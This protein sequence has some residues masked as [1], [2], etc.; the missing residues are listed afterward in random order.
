MQLDAWG[1]ADGYHDIDGVWHETSD[2]TRG[3]LRAAMGEPQ[4]IEPQWFVAA[5]TRH[6]L[7]GPCRLVL[8]DGTDRGVIDV[9]DGDV[10]AGYHWLH[11]TDGGPTTWL[12]VHPA[13]CPPAPAGWGAAA[14]TYSLWR[15][16]GWGIGDLEDV[17]ELGAAVAAKGG[18][19]LLLSPLHAPAPTTPQEDS[20]YY[21]SSRRWLNPLLLPLP[22]PAPAAV[23]NTPGGRIER[24]TVWAA[25]RHALAEQFEGERDHEH[26][27]R[28]AELQGDELT[29]FCAYDALADEHGPDWRQWPSQFR[30]PTSP[31][32]AARL[33]DPT[34]TARHELVAWT[35]W[36]LATEL[37]DA[38]ETAAPCALIGDL[39]VG[40]SPDG[41]DTWIHQDLF[42]DG[43]IIGAP[44]DPFN[45]AGQVWGLP[46]MV[47]WQLRRAR[48]G[49]VVSLLRAGFAGV[50]GLRIDHVMGL[51]RQ[52][53][54]P[55]G[56]TPADG[57]YVYLPATDLVALVCLEAERAGAF[58]VGEDLGVV[59]PN[60]REVLAAVVMLGTKVWMFDQDAAAW[61]EPNLGTVTTHDLPTVAGVWSAGDATEREPFETLAS[62]DATAVEVLV[63]AHRAI[64]ASPARL[65]LATA[66]DLAGS[67][68]RP[69][70][71]GTQ[72]DHNWCHR[73][74]VPAVDLVAGSPGAAIVA[75]M[76]AERPA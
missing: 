17:G 48:Y 60:V 15:R 74:A 67:V 73:L 13:S 40:C 64:A 70:S 30:H 1:I 68:V 2:A 45:D 39:A 9:L 56:G 57:A 20:P 44:P 38:A 18:V 71:P 32:V 11:P 36:R 25:K 22:G 5:G 66:D 75:A 8:E 27:R 59:E 10:P 50:G 26:W 35:Q 61:P 3:A 12:V 29:L 42:A 14:Q 46:P 54:V 19:A 76:Q 37:A 72:G 49:P 52:F 31:G 65:V 6:Q 47:P 7:L 21:P 69:N 23:D 53:W 16:D 62:P 55:D 28:W 51:F 58:V 33:A 63:A 4:P 43:V 24:D 34:L 41:A